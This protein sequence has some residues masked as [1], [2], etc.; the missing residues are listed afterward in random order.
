MECPNARFSTRDTNKIKL[1]TELRK[2]ARVILRAARPSGQQRWR[3]RRAA[4]AP[5]GPSAARVAA[6][7]RLRRH[8]ARRTTRRLQQIMQTYDVLRSVPR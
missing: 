8:G 5:L 1:F 3:G 2:S 7:A 6:A 4:G